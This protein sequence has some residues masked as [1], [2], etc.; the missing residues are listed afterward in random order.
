[1]VKTEDEYVFYYCS[2]LLDGIG[3]TTSPDGVSWT[4]YDDPATTGIGYRN[5]D[6]FM[7]RGETG[8]WDG[9]AIG[10]PLVRQRNGGWEMFYSGWPK[11]WTTAEVGYATSEDGIHWTRFDGNPVLAVPD[12]AI[13]LQSLVTL[14]DVYYV[15]YTVWGEWTIRVATGT[16]TWE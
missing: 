11:D 3:R 16:V 7:V 9:S 15:Y 12:E 1:M 13:R 10:P 8:A 14:D 2:G 5:S 6:P 4:K